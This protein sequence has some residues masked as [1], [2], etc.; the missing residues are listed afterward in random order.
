M[1][2]LNRETTICRG[3]F[4]DRLTGMSI[5]NR[6]VSSRDEQGLRAHQDTNAYQVFHTDHA[7]EHNVC[8]VI[9]VLVVDNTWAVDE[10]D[11]LHEG[12]VLPHLGLTWHWRHLAHLQHA[13]TTPQ[14]HLNT[15]RLPLAA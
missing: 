8:L 3:G 9:F 11:A 13:T 5:I 14:L 4:T 6:H 10:K 12:D 15:N 7:L 2:T 1:Q